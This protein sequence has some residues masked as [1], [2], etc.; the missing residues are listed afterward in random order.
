MESTIHIPTWNIKQEETEQDIKYALYQ[1][2]NTDSVNR[3]AMNIDVNLNSSAQ[4]LDCKVESTSRQS[5]SIIEQNNQDQ[6]V[7]LAHHINADTYCLTCNI[8]LDSALEY[9]YHMKVYHHIITPTLNSTIE[10]NDLNHYCHLCK[11]SFTNRSNYHKHLDF[12][13]EMNVIS[14]RRRKPL[15]INLIPDTHNPFLYCAPCE[16]EFHSSLDFSTHLSIVH[17]IMNND[18]D[19]SG[20]AFECKTCNCILDSKQEYKAHY[21]QVHGIHITSPI[22]DDILHPEITPDIGD[23]HF[24]CAACDC[25]FYDKITYHMHLFDI[26]DMNLYLLNQEDSDEYY[27]ASQRSFSDDEMHQIIPNQDDVN[28]HCASC[29]FTF[30]TQ[31]SYYSHLT[32]IHKFNITLS[33]NEP[34][35]RYPSKLPDKYCRFN[36]CNICEFTFVRN[37]DFRNHL[38]RTHAVGLLTGEHSPEI[39]HTT[40]TPNIDNIHFFCSVCEYTF[41][42][43]DEY[44]RHL[45]LVHKLGPLFDRRHTLQEQLSQAELSQPTQP[46]ITAAVPTLE[47]T[48]FYCKACNQQYT[49]E[50]HYH[51]HLATNHGLNMPKK[52]HPGKN[53]DK[54][55]AKTWRKSCSKCNP[56]STN[57]SFLCKVHTVSRHSRRLKELNAHCKL[58]DLKYPNL[59]AYQNHMKTVHV[60]ESALNNY[61][62]SCSLCSKKFKY[63]ACLFSHMTNA[64][65][66][67]GNVPD[68][69]SSD[70]HCIPCRKTYKN[71]AIE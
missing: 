20:H 36:Y 39:V 6:D 9:T 8:H 51:Q 28:N 16:K 26:H 34:E 13:H 2:T 62:A 24:N 60:R 38:A 49:D 54:P 21:V 5:S 37:V 27:D 50:P 11:I 33:I 48:T 32:I 67:S 57:T 17:R 4:E 69:D 30:P 19:I 42:S 1:Q 63:G 52:L 40:K 29:K 18:L 71:F 70:N 44:H 46:E 7:Y 56:L 15:H 41:S 55:N 68:V 3:N 35:I 45:S 25:A 23:P 43:K 58:C 22:R 10:I 14:S 65:G 61:I 59:H 66:I 47:D 64:H 31:S 12:I 53:V